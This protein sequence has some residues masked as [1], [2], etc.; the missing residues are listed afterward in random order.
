MIGVDRGPRL[1][2]VAWALKLYAPSLFAAFT[3]AAHSTDAFLSQ[4]PA[5]EVAQSPILWRLLCA[6]HEDRNPLS[7]DTKSLLLGLSTGPRVIR[8]KTPH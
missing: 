3:N 8:G 7:M 6:Q 2:R 4:N 5:S 1:A